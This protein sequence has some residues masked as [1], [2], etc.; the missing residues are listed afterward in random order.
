MASARFGQG[1]H[2]ARHPAGHL[3]RVCQNKGLPKIGGEG[4]ICGAP[5]PGRSLPSVTR[6]VWALPVY[7]ASR[8]YQA[9]GRVRLLALGQQGFRCCLAC[10]FLVVGHHVVVVREN[11]ECVCC[12]GGNDRK[13]SSAP[14]LPVGLQVVIQHIITLLL[15]CLVCSAHIFYDCCPIQT[16]GGPN[17][18]GGRARSGRRGIAGRSR[19][20]SA[21]RGSSCGW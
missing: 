12:V 15:R 16:G 19:W 18:C 14:E 21:C 7:R 8:G 6:V 10:S 1:P 4:G 11:T 17:R 20:C 2:V 9:S 5:L 3:A 13:E